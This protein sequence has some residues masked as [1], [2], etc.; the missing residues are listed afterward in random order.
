MGAAALDSQAV[1]SGAGWGMISILTLITMLLI[2]GGLLFAVLAGLIALGRKSKTALAVVLGGAAVVVLPL[3]VLGALLLLWVRHERMDVPAEYESHSLR[4]SMDVTEDEATAMLPP[5]RATPDEH[6]VE[7]RTEKTPAGVAPSDTATASSEPPVSPDTER[8]E[9]EGLRVTEEPRP[10][11]VDEPAALQGEVYRQ[12]VHAGPH[13]RR[14]EAEL[15]L[16]ERVRRAVGE[17]LDEAIAPGAAEL[18]EFPKEYIEDRIVRD[19]FTEVHKR[20]FGTLADDVY[21]VDI[22]AQLEFDSA[23]RREANERYRQAIVDD[24]LWITGFSLIG[25]LGLLGTVF[26][27]LRLDDATAGQ[28]RGRLRVVAVGM[29]LALVTAGV[30]VARWSPWM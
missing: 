29:I 19:Q 25:V 24:R 10:D 8:P 2:G 30:L 12:V 7:M 26:G 22:Y 13:P 16:E 6:S 3:L 11:W 18:V 28:R 17:Y 4:S 27:Y 9:P 21:M 5:S 23:I 14:L 15:E 20:S 1:A